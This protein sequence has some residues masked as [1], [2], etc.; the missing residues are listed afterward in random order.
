M[1]STI[2]GFKRDVFLIL[3]S[4]LSGGDK[5]SRASRKKCL[6]AAYSISVHSKL[7]VPHSRTSDSYAQ[8]PCLAEVGTRQ[9]GRMCLNL[10]YLP[11][12]LCCFRLLETS[13][14][15]HFSVDFHDFLCPRRSI[16]NRFLCLLL[17]RS[18]RTCNFEIQD[19][20]SMYQISIE[21]AEHFSG[22]TLCSLIQL[23]CT[24]SYLE[25]RSRCLKNFLTGFQQSN[26]A[27][28]HYS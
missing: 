13:K 12:F 14:N 3:L 4:I 2:L 21:H 8:W 7:D 26:F 20:H 19:L 16:Q 11:C 18:L 5:K 15:A 27:P 25:S 6:F 9:R 10:F 22:I 24:R 28:S 23:V 17:R 1:Y